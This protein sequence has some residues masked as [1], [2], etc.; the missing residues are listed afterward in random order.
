MTSPCFSL[1]LPSLSLALFLS[2]LPLSPVQADE[3]KGDLI[4]G[5]LANRYEFQTTSDETD[6]DL[7]D[8]ITVNLGHPQFDRISAAIHGGIITDLDGYQDGSVFSD[9]YNTFP[10]PV[11]G[12]IYDAYVHVQDLDLVDHVRFGRQ[13]LYRLDTHFFDGISLETVSL[14]GFTIS[15]FA[16]SPVHL[17]ENEWGMDP[18]DWTAGG[19]L[20]WDPI[21]PLRFRFDFSH[22]SDDASA[23]RAS[24]EDL[25]DNLLGASV[26]VTAGKHVELYSRFTSFT[27]QPRDL[28]GSAALSFPE[29]KF[30]VRLS[31]YRLLVVQDIR[32]VDWDAF[33]LAGSYRPYTQVMATL[34][35]GFG[36]KFSVDAGFALRL[37]DAWQEASAFNHGFRRYFLTLA[38]DD[39]LLKNFNLDATLDYYQGQDNEL[40]NDNVGTSFSAAKKFLIS[41]NTAAKKEGG[42]KKK[43]S[44]RYLGL[45][46]GTSYYLYRYNLSTGDESTDVQ[47]YFGEVQWDMMEHVK[48]RGSYEF[49]DNDQGD[50]QTVTVKTTWDF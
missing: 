45:R 20:Q 10:R 14:S 6:H 37:L 2:T 26:W 29:Q 21:S 22:I 24:G 19:S 46:G 3:K 48:L 31:A 8:F 18:G 32:V 38:T 11:V 40:R 17:Y 28:E 39:L 43:R 42:K 23:F 36:E 7:E 35:K 25:E 27:D 50:F 16:G 41:R 44:R 30:T 4:S 49:E 5:S 12:R 9:I 34:T 47:T 1:R 33:S 15:A 13:R